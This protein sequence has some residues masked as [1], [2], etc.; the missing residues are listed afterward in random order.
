[1]NRRH[2]IFTAG[3]AVAAQTLPSKQVAV[4]VIGA[5]ARGHQLLEACLAQPSVRVAAVC[6][7]YEPRMFGAVALAR[8]KGHGTRY[9]RIYGDLLADGDVEAV[10]VATPDFSHHRIVTEALRAAKDVYVE[11][12]LCLTWQEGVEL[13]E[14]EKSTRQ[15]IQVGSQRRSSPLF[16]ES[17]TEDVRVVQARGFSNYLRRGVL[18]R[19]GVKFREPLN[20]PDWQAGAAKQFPYSPDR[21]LNWRFYSMYGGG[22]VTDLGT[23]ILDGVHLLTGAGFPAV[24]EANG[25]RSSEE[26]F[27]TVERAAI[28]IRYTGGMLASLLIDGAAAGRH[29]QTLVSGDKRDLQVADPLLGSATS[30]HLANFFDA[31]RSRSQPVAP[32]SAT[33]PATL[34]CQMANL[35]IANG[36]PVRWDSQRQRVD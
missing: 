8:S 25:V 35:A 30:R 2:F 28:T 21:F 15:I 34:I 7:T 11:Q 20:F 18:R 22:P 33:L 36:G 24:V 16:R 27:D 4:G 19:G 32:V 10:I 13:L 23:P 14:A 9:Y 29:E 3:G 31:V 12:P 17:R 6:E 1:M 26:G 5:G